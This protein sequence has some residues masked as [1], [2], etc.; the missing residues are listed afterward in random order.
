MTIGTSL[1][2][3]EPVYR[4]RA[5]LTTDSYGDPVVASWEAP[6]RTLIRGAEA[7][8]GRNSET[9]ALLVNEARL[10]I[11]GGFPL[12]PFDRVEWEGAAWEVDGDPA[13][14]R[15]LAMGVYT[16]ANLKR[17]VRLAVPSG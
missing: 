6:E 3:S 11:R 4:L 8:P 9:G 12:N 5:P 7:Q 14:R 17:V 2:H 1:L 10:Y 13:T 16:T 15:S